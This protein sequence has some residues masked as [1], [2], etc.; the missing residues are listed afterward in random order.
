MP[1][2]QGKLIIE[3]TV[4]GL[5]AVRYPLDLEIGEVAEGYHLI[6]PSI[7]LSANYLLFEFRV[8]PR[9]CRGS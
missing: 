3:R 1:G 6:A 5:A 9:T 4:P 2:A 8:R 7:S